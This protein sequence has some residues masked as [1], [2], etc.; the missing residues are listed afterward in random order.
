MNQDHTTNLDI[1]VCSNLKEIHTDKKEIIKIKNKKI[2]IFTLPALIAENLEIYL[3][4]LFKPAKTFFQFIYP[5]SVFIYLHTKGLFMTENT[6]KEINKKS[7]KTRKRD[8][9]NYY[10]QTFMYH[11]LTILSFPTVLSVRFSTHISVLWIYYISIF[12]ASQHFSTHIWYNLL[13]IQKMELI[14]CE[15]AQKI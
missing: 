9:V 11:G 1:S 8:Y 7:H 5:F 3:T 4:I 10:L 12:G 6:H 2:S 13:I 15:N 14:Y